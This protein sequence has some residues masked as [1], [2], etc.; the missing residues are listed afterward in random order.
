MIANLFGQ[1]ESGKIVEVRHISV[2][3]ESSSLTLFNEKAGETFAPGRDAAI[4][5]LHRVS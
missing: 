1:S 4:L 2:N 5:A 3:D